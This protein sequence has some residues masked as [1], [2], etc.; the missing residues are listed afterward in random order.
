VLEDKLSV[1]LV[2]FFLLF[3][4]YACDWGDN[5]AKISTD[6]GKQSEWKVYCD[7]ELRFLIHYPPEMELKTKPPEITAEGRFNLL[8]WRVPGA[9]WF[10]VLHVHET[11]P[12]TRT[13]SLSKWLEDWGGNLEETTLD[14]NVAA[15]LRTS[16]FEA[17]FEKSVFFVEKSSYRVME[18]RLVVPKI[19]D[20]MGPTEK[21]EPQYRSQEGI[22]DRMVKS[23]RAGECP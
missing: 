13:Q 22:F 11:P 17:I 5:R 2:I 23:I 1:S 20:W 10:V 15:A 14:G 4:L 3:V 12:E 8:E 16:L 7:R 18:I 9:E 19:V 6:S 21:I